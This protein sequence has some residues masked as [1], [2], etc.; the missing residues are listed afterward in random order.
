MKLPKGISDLLHETGQLS[1]FVIR[2]SKE[3][4]SHAMSGKNF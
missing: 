3:D 2:F 1:A 4:L